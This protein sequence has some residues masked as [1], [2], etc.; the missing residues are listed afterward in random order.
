[1]MDFQIKRTGRRCHETDR[2]LKPGETFYSELVDEEGELTRRDLSSEAWDGPHENSIGWWQARVPDIQG[3]KVYWA[4][5]DILLSYFESLQQ[6]EQHRAAAYVMALLLVRKRILKLV[7]SI[8]QDG[9]EC[10]EVRYAKDNKTWNVPVV[11]LKNEQAESIQQELAQQL[12][13]DHPPE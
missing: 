6:H 11:E 3:G 8:E 2:E 5:R 1:M 7:D 4:P 13:T 10:L 9:I 12:F